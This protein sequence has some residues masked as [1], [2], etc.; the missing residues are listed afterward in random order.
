MEEMQMEN[1]RLIVHVP[2]ELDDHN[3]KKMKEQIDRILE[4]HWIRTLI[5]DFRETAFM[6]SSGIGMIL[7][8]YKKISY[9]GGKVKATHANDRI[10]RMMAI[11][12]LGRVIELEKR[13][14][15]DVQ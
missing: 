9:M 2:K 1:G 13:G 8:R 5:F 12:G 15:Q 7:G 11:S 3:A 6:D 10:L 4:T 14:N